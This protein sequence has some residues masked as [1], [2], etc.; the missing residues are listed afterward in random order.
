MKGKKEMRGKE[1][2]QRGYKEKKLK[3]HFYVGKGWWYP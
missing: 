2:R 3:S 1:K